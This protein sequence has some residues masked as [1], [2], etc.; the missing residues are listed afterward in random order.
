[1]QEQEQ[2]LNDAIDELQTQALL[3]MP[4]H[5][6]QNGA[7]AQMD[8]LSRQVDGANQQSLV[9]AYTF[10]PVEDFAKVGDSA[11]DAAQASLEQ[12]LRP[13]AAWPATRCQRAARCR[14]GQVPRQPGPI[15]A[16]RRAV[17][18]LQNN[19]ERMGNELRALSLE[20]GKRKVEQ[21]DREALAAR[22]LLTSVALL[23]LVAGPWL[24]G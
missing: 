2:K 12:L 17:E 10:V 3:N 8:T 11:L 19:M 18:Q 9:P 13:G 5:S 7:L 20:L 15:S 6:Q 4:A 16:R 24:P 23:A 14:A 21:R 22:S 1:M